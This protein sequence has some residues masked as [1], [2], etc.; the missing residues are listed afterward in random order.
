MQNVSNRWLEEQTKE[1]INYSDVI[2]NIELTNPNSATD[3]VIT[4]N[5]KAS[6]CIFDNIIEQPLYDIP[7]FTTLERNLW[8]L[9]DSFSSIPEVMDNIRKTGY[10]SESISGIQRDYDIPPKFTIKYNEIY[11]EL[12]SGVTITWSD[13][14]QEWAK[15]FKVSVYAQDVL[16]ATHVVLEN[17]K[18]TSEVVFDF[19]NYNKIEVEV[20]RWCLPHRR[21]RME[22]IVVG[23]NKTLTKKELITYTHEQDTNCMSATLPKNTIEFSVDNVDKV[24]NFLNLNGINKYFIERQRVTVKYGFKIDDKFEYI[25]GGVFYLAEWST[26]QNGLE[27]KFKATSILD[28]LNDTYYEGTYT[29]SGTTYYVLADKVLR[30]ANLP[31]IDKKVVW[32]LDN[33]LKTFI[34]TAPLP[35]LPLNQC[36]QL[37]AQATG[38]VIYC[39]RQGTI[40]IG[41]VKNELTE[42]YNIDFKIGFK[43]P[44]IELAK[45]LKEVKTKCYSYY[46]TSDVREVFKG[47][48]EVLGTQT[49]TLV[50][51]DLAMNIVPTITGGTLVSAKYF[52]KACEL[53]ITS[54]GFVNISL[55]GN[56]VRLSEQ[57]ITI[58]ANPKGETEIIENPLIVNKWHADKLG[59]YIKD[60]LSKRGMLSTEYRADP[61]IDVGDI[62]NVKSDFADHNII[63]ERVVI[64]YT[65]MFKGTVEGRVAKTL[66]FNPDINWQTHQKIDERFDSYINT[67]VQLLPIVRHYLGNQIERFDSNINLTTDLFYTK[68]DNSIVSVT[69]TSHSRIVV[70]FAK[71]IRVANKD[72]ILVKDSQNKKRRPETF[73]VENNKILT[74]NYKNLWL[75]NGVCNIDFPNGSLQNMIYVNT[76]AMNT[77]FVLALENNTPTYSNTTIALRNEIV[78]GEEVLVPNIT[79][80][81]EQSI[82]TNQILINYTGL[83]IPDFGSA[84]FE[85]TYKK[86][87]GGDLYETN[88]VEVLSVETTGSWVWQTL[89][90]TED[91][92]S[93][94][95]ITV[96]Y[97][98][99]LF[100]SDGNGSS[101]GMLR[102]FTAT[103]KPQGCGVGIIS[104][105]FES[106]TT[107]AV[108]LQRIYR[109]EAYAPIEKFDSNIDLIVELIPITSLNT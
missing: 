101:D 63:T 14:L 6:H 94:S 19:N 41:E 7:K 21:A 2:I 27:A 24:F 85:I 89:L 33:A 82:K 69:V 30:K 80:I 68:T 31:L 107:V 11:T 20:L 44:E 98:D 65:G 43:K 52:S 18:I 22:N 37:I 75:E 9:D 47:T 1:I 15:D 60:M 93:A 4:S 38:R 34:T 40:R 67:K 106:N 56:L 45:P 10:I 79:N 50:Y 28:F 96:K 102:P 8:V 3:G 35:M 39:D 23:L 48:I 32:E 100:S 61:R 78:N 13:S 26:P 104:E 77:N 58:N 25:D 64:D 91:F 95:E 59:N 17:N 71:D 74:L 55:S 62:I 66:Y 12:V 70:V 42:N 88:S 108:E 99:G 49:I 90:T 54:T 109:H 5:S 103:F 97:I 87:L 57:L 86:W 16:I 105:K 76:V 46:G 72:L 29:P 81:I 51:T 36:L 84:L 83:L 53:T 73:T 92:G